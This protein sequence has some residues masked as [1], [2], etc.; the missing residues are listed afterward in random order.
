MA[1]PKRGQFVAINGANFIVLKTGRGQIYSVWL[2]GSDGHTRLI[3]E[4]AFWIEQGA[5]RLGAIK[6]KNVKWARDYCR[7]H[8]DEVPDI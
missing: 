4:A 2:Y 5:L 3:T 7:A 8:E 1:R 6:P